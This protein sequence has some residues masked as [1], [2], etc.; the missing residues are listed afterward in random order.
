MVEFA[1]LS[2]E[3]RRNVRENFR[4]VYELP[5]DE[6]QALIK[7]Y[8]DLPPEGTGRESQD[9]F[10]KATARPANDRRKPDTKAESKADAKV[11]AKAG[12]SAAPNPGTP[13]GAPPDLPRLDAGRRLRLACITY[14]SLLLFGLL[15]PRAFCC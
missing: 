12:S 1:K 4:K 10:T 9:R 8:N 5:I 7:K 6:R 15:S 2:P 14:E 11:D 13:G 3:Q